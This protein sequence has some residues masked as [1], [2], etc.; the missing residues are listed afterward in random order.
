MKHLTVIMVVA[1]ATTLYSCSKKKGDI[2]N[3]QPPVTENPGT[4]GSSGEDTTAPAPSLL[5]GTW[6]LTDVSYMGTATVEASGQQTTAA[7]TGVGTKL[8]L[9]LLFTE[10]PNKYEATGDYTMRLTLDAGGAPFEKVMSFDG[11]M[12][13]GQWT[14]TD[15]TL[16]VKAEQ[17]TLEATIMQLTEDTLE[18]KWTFTGTDTP[19]GGPGTIVVHGRYRFTR[20]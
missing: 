16:T 4:G 20:S 14:Q 3:P 6:T 12:D 11:F 1:M 18:L 15:S 5:T 17:E 19:I 9:K 8:N 10:N 2:P 13:K 7:F